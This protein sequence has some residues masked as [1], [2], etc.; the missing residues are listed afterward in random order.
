VKHHH[1]TNNF[2]GLPQG[3]SLRFGLCC[4]DPSSLN[5]PHPPYSQAHLNFGVLRFICDA[6]AVRERLGDPRVVLRFRCSFLPSMSPP[7]SP[8]SLSLHTP[9]SFATALAFTKGSQM[10]RHSRRRTISG[11]TG[12]PLLRPAELLASL[13]ETF[14]S[15]LSADRSPSP[16]PG[17]TTVATG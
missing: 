11:L 17:I 3:P 15:G 10:V 12:S 4:P 1:S 7:E 6:F 2:V 5:R 8:G 16:L 9:S 13:T 14:T